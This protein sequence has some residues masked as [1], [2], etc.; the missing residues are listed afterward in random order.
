M[1]KFVLRLILIALAGLLP[2]GVLTAVGFTQPDKYLDTFYAGLLVKDRRLR[3]TSGKKR[4]VFLG[5]SSLSFGL[6]SEHLSAALGYEVVD[7]GLYAPLGVKTMA[8]LARKQIQKG[9]VVVFAPELSAE[10]Y[11]LRMD[12]GML[13]KCVEG[14]PGILERLS[15]DDRFET[16]LAYPYFV[17]ERSTV[18]ALPV[19]PYDR[20]S[21]NDYGD[22]ESD[23]AVRNVMPSLYDSG[24]MVAPSESMV[25]K[26]FVKYVNEY[27]KDMKRRGAD[28][29]FTFSPTNEL[30]LVENGLTKFE[31]TLSKKLNIPVLGHVKDFTYHENWFFDTNYHLNH[32]GSLVHSENIALYLAEA[33]GIEMTYDFPEEDMPTPGHDGGGTVV[34]TEGDFTLVESG[35]IYYLSNVDARLKTAS[36]LHIPD[37]IEGHA[38]EG[39]YA[40]ALEGF[41][42]LETVILPSHVDNLDNDIFLSC[43]NLKAIYLTN[44]L[45]P[46]VVGNGFL[47]GTSP[48]V[49]IYI[50]RSAASSYTSGYTWGGY[51][52]YFKLYNIEDLPTATE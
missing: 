35:G 28:T 25:Q 37:E 30:S 47:N 34:P 46:A 15:M 39:I 24:Q 33:L 36:I 22:I 17:Y 26:D 50:L 16:A 51:R 23:A 32:A 13:L 3:D 45:A 2:L 4:I 29:Y 48:N 8:E 44:A 42:S 5:G 18:E 10:T 7:Y 38:V 49:R 14:E 41:E 40:H 12:R 9:D 52:N 6:R 11:S 27:A 21:F 19:A 43:P 1:K 31:T 20:A